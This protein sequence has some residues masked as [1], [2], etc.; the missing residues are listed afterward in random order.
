MN[1]SAFYGY[2]NVTRLGKSLCAGEGFGFGMCR[3]KDSER[4]GGQGTRTIGRFHQF[5]H[6]KVKGTP[7]YVPKVGKNETR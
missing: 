4:Q 3:G 5:R 7:G 6:N 1:G 2:P